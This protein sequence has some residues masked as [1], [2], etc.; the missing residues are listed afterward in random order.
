MFASQRRCPGCGNVVTLSPGL[1]TASRRGS[2]ARSDGR[3]VPRYQCNLIHDP[4]GVALGSLPSPDTLV[5]DPLFCDAAKG[6]FEVRDLSPAL[7]SSCGQVGARPQ[8]CATFRL[9]PSR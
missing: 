6:I 9:A 4:S 5:G 1:A 2:F 3:L 8:G 7:R